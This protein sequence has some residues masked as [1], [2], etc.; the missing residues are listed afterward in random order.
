MIK[1]L[2]VLLVEDSEDDAV[3]VTREL[4]KGG[5]TPVI[6]RVETPEDM[7]K[8]LVE[9][10][11]DLIVSDYI[12]PCFSGLNALKVL[13]KSG[14]DLPFIVVSG[15]IGEDTAV[16][17]MRA[18]AHDYIMKE[19]LARLNPAVKREL[20]DAEIRQKRRD[21]EKDLVQ[22]HKELEKTNKK[23]LEEILERKKLEK[24]VLEEKEYL[25]NVIDSATE[26]IIAVDKNNRINTWNKSAEQMTGYKQKDVTNRSI[27][28]LNLFDD[29]NIILDT[30]KTVYK[31]KRFGHQDLV[32]ITKNNEKRIIRLFGS[33]IRGNENQ[34][35][36]V[37]FV[38]HDITKDVEIHGKLIDGKSYIIP[39]KKNDSAFDIFVDL[40]TSD[41]NGLLITR[42]NPL[43][44]KS[45][46]SSKNIKTVILSQQKLEGFENISTLEDLKKKIDDFSKRNKNSVILLDGI[47]YLFTQFSFDKF[48]GVLY[49]LNEIILKN[50]SI[51][52]LRIDPSTIDERQMAV[53][54]NELQM[55]PSQKVEGLVIQDEVYEILKF[56][57]E[58]NQSNAIVP[59]KKIMS[60]FKIS[61][62]TAADRVETLERKGLAFT[63][64]QG[65]LRTAYVTEKGKTLLHKR[66]TA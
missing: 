3:L 46:T 40:T 19:N 2:R 6:Q 29:S 17:A 10:T 26:I 47:H 21:A 55:L 65:K 27:H 63:K 56:I 52:F 13:K 28:K 43:D 57:F 35:L 37:L 61:F 62:S 41:Y 51:M 49:Q 12:L 48:L 8:A 18:G 42:S 53:I 33:A 5:Y 31:E 58:Q 34:E 16:E 54:E 9:K 22:S 15:K 30:I 60:R 23:L 59:M 45:I 32:L 44:I 36:G 7:Q 64:R 66:Q 24:Q 38:G 14:I 11:W 20:E 1:Q 50:K 4:K 39:D 25:Q